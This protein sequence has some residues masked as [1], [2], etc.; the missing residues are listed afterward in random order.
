MSQTDNNKQYKPG[1]SKLKLISIILS[2]VFFLLGII[3]WLRNFIPFDFSD[4]DDIFDKAESA[5]MSFLIGC[6]FYLLGTL[7]SFNKGKTRRRYLI[8]QCIYAILI[9]L[10][11]LLCYYFA[12]F[13]LEAI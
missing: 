4:A 9:I 3:L 6:G 5:M 1:R 11:L 7:D 10:L 8:T 2:I 13:V 12:H